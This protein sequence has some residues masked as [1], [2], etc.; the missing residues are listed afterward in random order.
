MKEFEGDSVESQDPFKPVADILLAY[1]NDIVHNPSS[2]SLD[3]EAL[4]ES[5]HEF[6]KGLQYF[7]HCIN[8]SKALTKELAIGNLDCALPSPGN[9]IASSL[10]MLYASL[11]HLTWQTQ[12]VA[13]GDYRQRVSFM[14]DFSAAFNNMVEQLE[15]RRKII[16]DEKNKLEMYVQLILENCPNPIL[17][18][19]RDGKLAYA[20]DSYFYFC[21][22]SSDVRIYGKQIHDLFSTIVSEDSLYEIEQIY[23]KAIIE[24]KVFETEQDIVFKSDRFDKYLKI[25]IAPM[26]NEG[27]NV[28]GV[29]LFI[30]DMTETIRARREAERARELAEQSTRTKSDFLAKTSHEIRTPMNA[31]LGMVEL[32]LR[33][34]ISS[35]AGKHLRTIRQAGFNLMTII[36]DILDFSK[37]EAGKLEI[38]PSEYSFRS[39]IDDILNIIKMRILDSRLRFV[40]NIDSNIPSVLFGDTIR[41]R[42]ILLNLLSN[43]IKYTEKGFVGLSITVETIND[44]IVTLKMEVSD[45][46]RG[47]RQEEMGLLFSN[48]TRLDLKKN[49]TIEGTGLGLSITLGLVTAIN[50]KIDVQSEYGKGSTFTITLP[51]K[52]L[53]NEK[54]AV[55]ENPDKKSVLVFERREV[56]SNSII[57]TL[58]NLGIGYK[59]VL[60]AS[61]FIDC[62]TS[63]DYS[64]ALLASALYEEVKDKCIDFKQ[65][66]NFAVIVE[67][68]EVISNWNMSILSRPVFSI[69]LANFLNGVSD[70]DTDSLKIEA[71]T[72]FIA[73][74]AK[75][76][77]VDDI[78]TNLE[79]IK[80]LLLPYKMQTTL[81]KSGIEAIEEIKSTQYDLVF[82]DLMM[83]EMDGVETVSHIR[84][85][86]NNNPYYKNVPIVAFT[87][88]AVSGTREIMLKKGFDDFLSKPIDITNLDTILEKWTPKEKQKIPTENDS[89]NTVSPGYKKSIKIGGI[90]V[91]KGIIMAGGKIERYQEILALFHKDGIDKI[92]KIKTCLE[93]DNITLYVIYI[94]A[95]KSAAG[96]VGADKIS[97]TASV[98]EN[99]GNNDDFAFIQAHSPAFLA[100]FETLLRNINLFLS[101]GAEKSQVNLVDI[102]KELLRAELSKLKAALDNFDF[103]GINN[104]V[105]FLQG[106]TQA[107]GIGDSISSILQYKLIG[108]YDEAILLIDALLGW[109]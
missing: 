67:F 91:E 104:A 54:I 73:P 7:S 34:D 83:P 78:N 50:G 58:L 30:F 15:Q 49:A 82:M 17:L 39:L 27:R 70:S 53:D 21:R 55:V 29:I 11:K 84:A 31:I 48:F 69:S 5:F 4:P 12:Q 20:S 72:R 103:D 77:I 18:F 60:T 25:Q 6:G 75:L 3:I 9:E 81:C 79:V 107:D 8:E 98:L 26:L 1:L 56:Y 13:K 74:E 108:E 92:R 10:K 42:Q 57:S 46:G 40:V 71:K 32:A 85:L 100:E 43:A 105:Q 37:I 24:K 90:N 88:N 62:L 35:I 86:D 63:K 61:D 19:D 14:G 36:N 41:I 45:T 102:D 106:F 96:I 51:Q 95:L 16:L 109:L 101:K 65:D 59:L 28:D 93:T 76:L 47:I 87:A 66:V 52:I 22:T 44:D 38:T 97:E 33:E 2:A 99:A 64:F 94:H 23:Q 80:G 89:Q 68:G